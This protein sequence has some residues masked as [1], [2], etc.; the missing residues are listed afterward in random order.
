MSVHNNSQV[1]DVSALAHSSHNVKPKR[2]IFHK[3]ENFFKSIFSHSKSHKAKHNSKQWKFHKTSSS[4]SV[5]SSNSSGSGS[6]SETS[7]KLNGPKAF[8]TSFKPS[9][10]VA[11]ASAAAS[12]LNVPK[13]SD[14]SSNP[15]L[16]LSTSSSI[17]FNQKTKQY[18]YKHIAPSIKNLVISGGGAKGVILPGVL[19]AFEKHKVGNISFRDSLENIAGASVGALTAA[20]IATGMSAEEIISSM[21]NEDFKELLGKSTVKLPFDIDLPVLKDGK[22]LLNLLRSFTQKSI[23]KNLT[24]M[25]GV[26]TLKDI[27]DPRP[28]VIAQLA[29]RNVQFTDEKI[30]QIVQQTKWLLKTLDSKKV[31]V[32]FSMLD[33]LSELDPHTFK[34]L[35]VTAVSSADGQLCYFDAEK[36][37]KLDIAI[38]CRASA[39]L[40]LVLTPVTIPRRFLKPGYDFKTPPKFVDGGY[41]DNAPITPFSKKQDESSL[42][43]KGIVGQDLQTLVLVYDNANKAEGE[44]SSFLEVKPK[45]NI[46]SSFLDRVVCNGLVK[47]LAGIHTE[48]VHTNEFDQKMNEIRMNYTQRNIP[49]NVASLG[50]TDFDQAKKDEEFH[51]KQGE[52]QA[53]KYLQNHSNELMYHTFDSMDDL[54]KYME[55]EEIDAHREKIENF[56]ELTQKN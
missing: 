15:C 18:V 31:R 50:T 33:A 10:P 32:T 21:K 29:K 13:V 40:P 27:K 47:K 20:L 6:V 52:Q 38:A 42:K 44:Q 11:P 8:D 16:E 43:N 19:K 28:F 9:I 35:T 45:E 4:K 14:S 49:L 56:I 54:Q 30:D 2:K 39:A 34:K 24:E 55:P 41:L 17:T 22:P 25:F 3:F 48:K 53:R 46:S 51:V 5:S 12:T 37:P 7:S 26:E 36:T 23:T 1:S